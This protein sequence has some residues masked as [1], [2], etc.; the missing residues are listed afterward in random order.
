VTYGPAT[1]NDLVPGAVVFIA[2]TKDAKGAFIARRVVVGVLDI[3]AA[4][5]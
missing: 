3:G 4:V 1:N 5:P 2:A